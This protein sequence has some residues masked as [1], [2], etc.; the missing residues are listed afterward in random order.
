MN[1]LSIILFV[2]I[3]VIVINKNFSII[4]SFAKSEIIILFNFF[5]IALDILFLAMI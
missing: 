3:K 2:I 1:K 4:Y 5:L